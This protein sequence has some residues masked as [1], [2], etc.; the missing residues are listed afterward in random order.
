MM[1]KVLFGLNG[2]KGVSEDAEPVRVLED[3]HRRYAGLIYDKCARMLRDHHDAE[4]AV[5]ETF[6]QAHHL[7]AALKGRA[8]DSRLPWLYRIA[9]YVCLHALRTR[10]RKGIARGRADSREICIR[11]NQERQVSLRQQFDRVVD[12]LDERTQEIFVSHYIDG[13]TQGEIAESLGISR[14]AVVK[15]LTALRQRLGR[16]VF[17]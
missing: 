5:Q 9:T 12:T 15:R 6:W 11:P 4:D 1:F 10:R 14:R 2:G 7:Q 13:M 8:V 3:L 17:D 16:A